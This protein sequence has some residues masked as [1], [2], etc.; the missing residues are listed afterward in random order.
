MAQI[1]VSLEDASG[2]KAT[3][4]GVLAAAAIGLVAWHSGSAPADAVSV[5]A[6]AGYGH[7]IASRPALQPTSARRSKESKGRRHG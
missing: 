7:L 5:A 4:R 1:T 2:L 3:V 6:A